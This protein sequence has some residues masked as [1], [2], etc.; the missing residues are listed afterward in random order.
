M[1]LGRSEQ[2]KVGVASDFLKALCMLTVQMF[3]FLLIP[4]TLI[5]CFMHL[6]E[7]DF[8]PKTAVKGGIRTRMV[9]FARCVFL[10]V[11]ECINGVNSTG[12]AD[13]FHP[14]GSGPEH[15]A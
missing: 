10:I 12:L 13:L 3:F 6:S 11:F 1:I 2:Q 7:S 8:H 9:N 4:V 15:F 5:F 14:C